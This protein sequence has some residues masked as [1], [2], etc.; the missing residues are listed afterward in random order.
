MTTPASLDDP[1]HAPTPWGLVV[2]LGA[3]TAIGALSTDMYLP[4]LPSIST[5]LHAAAGAGQATLASFFAGLAIGQ[6]F[7]GPA[8][9][10]WGRRWPLLVG[11]VLYIAASVV[12]AV[13]QNLEILIAARFLQ[14]ASGCAGQ[15]ISRAVIRDRFAHRQGAQVLSRLMLIMGIAPILAPL[16]GGALLGFGGWRTIF[17]VLSAFGLAMAVWLFVGLRETRSAATAAQ[18][19][20]EHPLRAYLELL[21]KRVLLGYVL[22]GAFNSAA[23]F[24][25]LAASPGLLIQTYGIAP[26]D[27]GWVFGIN[28]IGLI[29]MSQ[30]NAHLLRRHTPETILLRAR[31]VSILFAV[32]LVVDAF[33][34][35][36][37]EIGVLAPLFMVIGSFGFVGA[38]SQSSGLN[39]DPLRAGS[40]SALMGGASFGSGA[41][42][43]A[44][45]T[46]LTSRFPNA[47]AKPMA[48]V[49]LLTILA[50]SVALY[51]MTL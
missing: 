7:Y 29:G 47:G 1:T 17:W 38:N 46:A 28:A 23:L 40:I 51:G 12:C 43:S 26:A 10:R 41:L 24:A 44:L 37:G 49:I 4:S 13:A 21:K 3:L 9:D 30:V 5:D 32:V 34:G 11:M 15:V 20:R 8:S 2:M 48:C 27:F 6:L 45:T 16:A 31:P 19:R 35:W 33:T 18:A 25:Y 42:V 50:S 22:A 39:V 14:G 36:G